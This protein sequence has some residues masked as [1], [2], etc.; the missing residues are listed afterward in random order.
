MKVLRSFRYIL[1]LFIVLFAS[2]GSA[3]KG[4]A[5]NTEEVEL[6]FSDKQKYEYYYLEAIR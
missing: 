2:C 6:A 4:V 1:L 3:R 5:T